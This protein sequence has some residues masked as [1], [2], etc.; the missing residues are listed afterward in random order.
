MSELLILEASD[1]LQ[2]FDPHFACICSK[3][4]AFSDAMKSVALEIWSR[5]HTAS[6]TSGL[7][8]RPNPTLSRNQPKSFFAAPLPSK[9]L[10]RVLCHLSTQPLEGEA[11]EYSMTS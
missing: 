9:W 1:G 10:L 6:C 3:M 7:G 8:L 2:V 5:Q 4:I 11:K